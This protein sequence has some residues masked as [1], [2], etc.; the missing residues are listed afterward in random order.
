[1]ATIWAPLAH[2]RIST[3]GRRSISA[4]K[5]EQFRQWLEQGRDPPPV[6][7]ARLGDIYVVRDGRH[8]IAAALAAGH[9]LIEAELQRIAAMARAALLPLLEL[10]ADRRRGTPGTKL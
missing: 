9:V 8:R 1:M 6:R 5:V 2:I 3:R 10:I 4:A 7:L